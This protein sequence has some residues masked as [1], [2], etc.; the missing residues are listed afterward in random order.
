M[1]WWSCEENIF[2]CTDSL[3]IEY[4]QSNNNSVTDSCINL[5][6]LGCTNVLASNYNSTASLND[7]SCIIDGCSDPAY[8]EYSEFVTTDDGSCSNLK[9]FGCTDDT[10]LEY[11]NWEYSEFNS[12]LYVIYD[13]VYPIANTDN[14]SCVTKLVYGCFYDVYIQYDPDVNVFD[15]TFCEDLVNY[16]CTDLLATNYDST[17][18]IDDAS[19]LIEG[20]TNSLAFNYESNANVDNGSC[21]PFIYGCTIFGFLNYNPSAN[22]DN[23]TCSNI[24]ADIIDNEWELFWLDLMQL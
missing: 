15:V 3:Y 18:T 21:V 8:L 17:A 16:G 5:H 7:G 23:G 13:A 19:C 24:S 14:G 4:S 6:V 10:Y 20:C 11:W 2:G 12:N 1:R 9:V 22:M